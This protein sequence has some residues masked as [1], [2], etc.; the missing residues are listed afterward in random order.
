MEFLGKRRTAVSLEITTID[1]NSSFGIVRCCYSEYCIRKDF[2]ICDPTDSAAPCEPTRVARVATF[3]NPGLAG[4]RATLPTM[5]VY[6]RFNACVRARPNSCVHVRA[7]TWMRSRLTSC[8]H[9][10]ASV[11]S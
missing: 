10:R 11:R 3:W 6:A 4:S 9:V 1:F 7:C 5:C 8:V 2:K